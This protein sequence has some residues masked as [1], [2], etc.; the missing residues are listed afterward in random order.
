MTRLRFNP[1]ERSLLACLSND[2]SVTLYDVST[3]SAMQK[4]T[5]Q[6]RQNALCWNPME[7]FHFTTASEDHD[8]YTFDMRRLDHAICVHK[9]QRASLLTATQP[10]TRRPQSTRAHTPHVHARRA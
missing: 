2:R 6:T 9:V 1:V 10:R 4:V 7:P 8:L 3:G 5:L